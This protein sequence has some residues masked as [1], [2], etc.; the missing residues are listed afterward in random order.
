MVSRTMLDKSSLYVGLQGAV[1]TQQ[2]E[3]IVVIHEGKTV[4][5]RPLISIE[6]VILFGNVT[7]TTQA[8]RMLL[9]DGHHVSYTTFNGQMIGQLIPPLNKNSI[10]R[11]AQYRYKFSNR[12][13]VQRCIIESKIN[14][15]RTM[16]QRYARR[17]D[18]PGLRTAVDALKTSTDELLK[19]RNNDH[20]MG[21][22]GNATSIYFSTFPLLLKQDLGFNGR[23]KRPP[24]DPVNAVLSLGYTL[25]AN[26]CTSQCY[27]VGYDPYCGFLHA[28]RHGK[29]SLALDIMEEFRQPVVDSLLFTLFNNYSLTPDDFEMENG[30][31]RF[32]KAALGKFL[33]Q[34]DEKIHSNIKHPY[35]DREVTYQEAIE[36]QLRILARYLKGELNSYYPYKIK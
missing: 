29:P 12:V 23:N 35:L 19:V 21:I 22:E 16:L 26:I 31:C 33:Q 34:Y 24:R 36:V 5:D 10:L 2:G 18:D 11:E 32:K 1:L 17:N 9:E 7:I 6:D 13:H 15:M 28:T 30:S 25:L 27:H 20:I 4:M 3:R 8:K 14:N